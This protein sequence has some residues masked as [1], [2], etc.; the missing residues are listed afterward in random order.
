MFQGIN[1]N[2]L[3]LPKECIGIHLEPIGHLPL[4]LLVLKRKRGSKVLETSSSKKSF[5]VTIEKNKQTT[6]LLP[7]SGDDRER[8]EMEEVTFLS[9][10]L[11]KTALAAEAQ[12]NIA[13]VQEKLNEEEIEKM[14]KGEE[15]EE[16]YAS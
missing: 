15:D 9:L 6:T 7:P 14:V 5:K 13:K 4:L 12:E 16:S 8:D 1:H 3:F 10:N 2:K 11:Y